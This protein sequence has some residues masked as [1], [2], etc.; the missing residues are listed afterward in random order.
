MNRN[1]LI[2]T[3]VE[4]LKEKEIKLTKTAM[5]EIEKTLEEVITKELVDGG[6]VGLQGFGTFEVVERKERE[7]RNPSTNEPMTIPASKGVKFKP[8]KS[9]KELVK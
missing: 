9:F 4:A 7:G 6:K 1:D 3:T 8:S 5:A 2:A